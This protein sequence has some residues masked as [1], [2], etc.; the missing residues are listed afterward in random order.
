MG[1]CTNMAKLSYSSFLVYSHG[2]TDRPNLAKHFFSHFSIF[3]ML[4]KNGKY[5]ENF[6]LTNPRLGLR[7]QSNLVAQSF[8]TMFHDIFVGERFFFERKII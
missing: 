8:L 4:G 1:Q 3:T 5:L 6:L 7:L 2:G